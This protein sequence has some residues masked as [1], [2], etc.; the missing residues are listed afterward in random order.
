MILKNLNVV[1]AVH[2]C[3]KG[4]ITNEALD[5]DASPIPSSSIRLTSVLE[6]RDHL[7]MV[8]RK[9]N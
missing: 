7:R 4:M 9:N 1:E 8:L 5:A 6:F 3:F 2:N